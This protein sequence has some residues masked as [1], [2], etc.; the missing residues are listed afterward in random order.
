MRRD[1]A[2]DLGDVEHALLSLLDEERV[3]FSQIICRPRGRGREEGLVPVVAAVVELDEGPDVDLLLPERPAETLPRA[4][5]WRQPWLSASSAVA[6]MSHSIGAP[7]AARRPEMPSSAPVCRAIIS[8]SLVGTTQAETRLP[9]VGDP[10]SVRLRWR[11]DPASRPATRTPRRSVDGSRR[12]CSPIPAVKT[13]AST[14]PSTAASA[15][16]CFAAW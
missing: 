4:N 13:S 7:P 15:P 10:G 1:R 14:P 12:E 16:T 9:A 2:G 3:S 5:P 11:P 8:S 6:V